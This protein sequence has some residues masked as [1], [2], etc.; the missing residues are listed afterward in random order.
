M[1]QFCVKSARIISA[2]G[3]WWKFPFLNGSVIVE[4]HSEA[5][6]VHIWGV[7]DYREI[8]TFI[9]CSCKRTFSLFDWTFKDMTIEC[10]CFYRLIHICRSSQLKRRKTYRRHGYCLWLFTVSQGIGMC[11]I[12]RSKPC[13]SSG[14]MYEVV[15]VCF[16][17]ERLRYLQSIIVEFDFNGFTW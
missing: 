9:C 12:M 5:E 1:A 11:W 15:Y 6:R 4:R 16:K 17:R 2:P 13:N 14:R 7:S 8:G 3:N 10:E